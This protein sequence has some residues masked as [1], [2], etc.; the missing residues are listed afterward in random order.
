MSEKNNRTGSGYHMG[1]KRIIIAKR[2]VSA[3]RGSGKREGRRGETG[4]KRQ[5]EREI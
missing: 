5:R 2:G 3:I 4:K 1:S